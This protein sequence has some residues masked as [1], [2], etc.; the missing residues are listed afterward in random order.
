MKYNVVWHVHTY[1]RLAAGPVAYY[2][3]LYYTAVY[4]KIFVKIDSF[5]RFLSDDVLSTVLK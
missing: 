5:L 1:A 2:F 3:L 4:I